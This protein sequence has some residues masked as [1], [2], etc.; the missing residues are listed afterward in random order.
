VSKPVQVYDG[1]GLFD[2]EYFIAKESTKIVLELKGLLIALERYAK[3][4]VRRKDVH[5]HDLEPLD[6]E[7][8]SQ[9][10][11][12]AKAVYDWLNDFEPY[13]L[14]APVIYRLGF[15]AGECVKKGFNPFAAQLHQLVGG[16][17]KIHESRRH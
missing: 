9:I 10:I 17:S 1:N 11:E 2:N 5:G 15:L 7:E 14:A 3:M 6:P 13:E 16:M 8:I 12:S 4:G